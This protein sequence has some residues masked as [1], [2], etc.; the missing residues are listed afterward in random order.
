MYIIS[1]SKLQIDSRAQAIILAREA[2]LT[3]N[4]AF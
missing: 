4:H 2:G 1:F 3:Q